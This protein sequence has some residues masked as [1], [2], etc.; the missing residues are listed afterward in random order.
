[1]KDWSGLNVLVI[2]AARQGVALA[3]YLALHGA[4]V[5][6]NDQ[7]QPEALQKVQEELSGFPVK[8]V[9]GGH[10]VGL[11]EGM[12]LVCP[13]GGVPLTLPLIMETVRRGI[14]LSNDSQIFMQS[15]PCP[16]I[17]I[18]GS[19]GKTT[20][21][22]LVGRM[23]MEF[24]KIEPGI[25]KVY[26]GGN[27]G[28]PLIS[29]VDEMTAEDWVVCEFSSFQLEIMTV[30]PQVAA[31]LNVTPNHLDRHETMEA[32]ASAKANILNYQGVKDLA[33]LNRDD[34]SFRSLKDKIHGRL[35]TFGKDRPA[36]SLEG[37]FVRGDD[38]AYANT[39]GVETIMPR[40]EISLRGAHNLMNSLAACAIAG[41][42][43]IPPQA[44]RSGI[45]GFSG[46][47]HRLQF[48]RR[49]SEIDWYNDSIA[50]APERAM[51][52]ILA[53]DEPIVLLAGGRD[54]D[55][56]WD[57]FAELVSQRVDHLILFGE[58]AQKISQ[59]FDA[60]ICDS[61]ERLQSIIEC[62]DLH[63]A[64]LEAAKVA[65][66]GDVVLLAPGGT[67]FDEFRDFEER[68]EWFKKWVNE[69]T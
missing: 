56:P 6:L 18:T 39:S 68:G 26:V 50:T 9:Y 10:P 20:T 32:Y 19:A 49:W 37:T 2:G 44:M 55:L 62:S 69:L 13:S 17:G 38:L 11:L 12:D 31:V 14:P 60:T 65:Q 42:V 1:M 34:P 52:A 53:F 48:V 64:V 58:A 25:R 15:A 51:A 61:G 16:V 29:F 63:Q 36:E 33:I 8:W 23:A 22:T 30:S 66:P 3:R 46:V 41:A 28:L 27:I 54:K 40:H 24:Q 57:E 43:G 7:R 4:R 47:P 35:V 45:V 59:Y 5:V 67:S 21:T